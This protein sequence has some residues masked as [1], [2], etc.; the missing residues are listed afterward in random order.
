MQ[1]RIE[2]MARAVDIVS[3]PL[4]RFYNMLTDEQKARLGAANEQ[5]GRNRG[6]TASCG[7]HAERHGRS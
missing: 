1:K 2:G 6:S 3:P 5:D 4:D 7:V